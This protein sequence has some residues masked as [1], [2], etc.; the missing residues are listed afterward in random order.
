MT[1]GAEDRMS[2]ATANPAE[3]EYDCPHRPQ[4]SVHSEDEDGSDERFDC[5]PRCAV[6][7]P[8]EP[9][10]RQARLNQDEYRKSNRLPG[11]PPERPAPARER[12]Q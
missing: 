9:G 12:H 6:Y 4:H 5:D 10:L 2:G 1:Q 3:A 7:E 8:I 11:T